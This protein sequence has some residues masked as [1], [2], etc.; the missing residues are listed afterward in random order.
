M[1]SKSTRVPAEN[2]S[3]LLVIMKFVFLFVFIIFIIIKFLIEI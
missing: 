1:W 2:D 3:Y